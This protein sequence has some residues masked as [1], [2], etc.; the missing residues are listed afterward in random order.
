VTPITTTDYSDT[1]TLKFFASPGGTLLGTSQSLEAKCSLTLNPDLT[2]TK[3]CNGVQVLVENDQVVIRAGNIITVTNTGQEDLT[4]VTI[5][6]TEVQTLSTP[7]GGTGWTCSAGQ[8]TGGILAK[9][10]SAVLTQTYIPDTFT[11]G[12]DPSTVKFV[13]IASAE[14]KGKISLK[15]VGPKED[16]AECPLCP[17]HTTTP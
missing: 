16:N 15:S 7:V 10:A 12:P 9:G 3:D 11:G 5:T 4:N 13:N 6:D 1:M 2:I 17:P 8:C 14:G